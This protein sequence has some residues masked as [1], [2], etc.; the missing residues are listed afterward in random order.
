MLTKLTNQINNQKTV[1][2]A[3]QKQLEAAIL[4]LVPIQT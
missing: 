1:I 4:A 3:L 2:L